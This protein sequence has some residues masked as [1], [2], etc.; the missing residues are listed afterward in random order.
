M[1]DRGDWIVPTFNGKLR[2]DKPPLHYFF[3]RLA[4]QVFGDG[5]YGARFFSSIFGVLTVLLTF[6]FAC[7]FLNERAGF[8][9]AAVLLCSLGFIFQFH[10]AVPDPYLI[11]FIGAAI[12][13]YFAFE[14]TN[15][16]KYLYLAYTAVG[17]GALTK[18]PI[19]IV[20]PGMAI[21]F[22]MIY[23]RK[24]NLKGII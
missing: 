18:G 11:F 22:Y 13:S 16:K 15:E 8:F 7:K 10:L 20:L 17:F 24:L 6:F 1:A 2:T 4:Y 12:C 3:M 19:A 5:A 21:F 9:S 14:Q 23:K